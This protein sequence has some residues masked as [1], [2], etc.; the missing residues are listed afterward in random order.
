MRVLISGASGLIGGALRRALVARGDEVVAVRGG[1]LVDGSVDRDSL[2]GLDAAV[3]LAGH[4]IASRARWNRAHKQRIRDSRIRGTTAL[5]TALASADPKPSVLVS[6]SAVGFYG[7]RGD[8]VLDEQARPGVGFLSE[9]VQ[10]WEVAARPAQ[11]EGI[12][13][14]HIRTGLVLDRNDGLLPRLLLPAR[15][16]LAPRFGDGRHW[17]SWISIEDQ[18]RAII[19]VIESDVHGPVNLVAPNPVTNRDMTA[20]V[21]RAVHRPSFL[22]VPAPLL[23]IALGEAADEVLLSGQRV[24][25]SVLTATGFAFTH[26][27]V[28]SALQAILAR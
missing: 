15:L 22:F 10:A 25:P 21:S 7:N 14:A 19:H 6:G 20:A 2:D 8:E 28:G 9:L 18:V 12:R 4:P 16:G 23:R 11:S 24:A 13:V 5:A 3:H 27:E 26:P 17:M 1:D